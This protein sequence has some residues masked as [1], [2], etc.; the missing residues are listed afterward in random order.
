MLE[1]RAFLTALLFGVIFLGGCD[2]DQQTA[3]NNARTNDSDMRG[4][5][6]EKDV[7]ADSQRMSDEPPS[8]TENRDNLSSY[9]CDEDG[10]WVHPPAPDKNFEKPELQRSKTAMTV[11]EIRNHFR[12][13]LPEAGSMMTAAPHLRPGTKIPRELYALLR[14]DVVLHL[15]TIHPTDRLD[16]A[17]LTLTVLVNYRPVTATYEKWNDSRTRVLESVRETGATFDVSRDVEL[18]DVTVPAD[19]FQYRGIHDLAVMYKVDGDVEVGPRLRRMRLYRGSY[20]R[21]PHPCL[22]MGMAKPEP[23]SEFEKEIDR[24]SDFVYSLVYPK[25]VDEYSDLKRVEARPGETVEVSYVLR[26]YPGD[27]VK[28]YAL[29]PLLNGRPVDWRDYVV[30][31]KTPDRF[32]F[33]PATKRGTFEVQLPDEPGEYELQ[34]GT[35]YNP[36]LLPS[37]RPGHG[38]RAEG[39]P[40]RGSNTFTFHV[41]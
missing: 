16:D 33:S 18:V 15:A 39:F 30:A 25:G 23:L 22:E 4:V 2:R 40:A 26:T 36:F 1:T 3:Q 37:D 6:A 11:G 35:W 14:E 12:G 28:P 27:E 21:P 17:V 20:D 7:Q 19:R 13:E 24:H 31:R 41:R 5:D 10:G 9:I 38:I 8:D 29:V 34:L 32:A